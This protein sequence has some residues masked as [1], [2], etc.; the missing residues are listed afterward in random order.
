MTTSNDV[1]RHERS[2]NPRGFSAALE[3]AGHQVQVMPGTGQVVSIFPGSGGAGRTVLAGCMASFLAHQGIKVALLDCGSTFD[4]LRTMFGVESCTSF[5]DISQG[6]VSLSELASS[7]KPNDPCII[8]V[9]PLFPSHAVTESVLPLIASDATQFFDAVIIDTPAVWCGL[10][11][12]L[13]EISSQVLFLMDQRP[14][15]VHACRIALNMCT[16]IGVATH[17]ISFVLNKCKKGCLFNAVD[18]GHVLDGMPVYELKDGGADV[19]EFCSAGQIEELAHS[20]NAFARSI[21]DMTCTL[22]PQHTKE[23]QASI[24]ERAT[25]EKKPRGFALGWGNSTKRGLSQQGFG[26]TR[27]RGRRKGC[28]IEIPRGARVAEPERSPRHAEMAGMP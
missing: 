20:S 24:D 8:G 1:A 9:L 19:D 26:H 12:R 27:R 7:C 13:M 23:A 28:Q 16:R 18:V 22:L 10:H 3:Q 25:S 6:K 4:E 15:S 17:P 11:T 21:A 14:S 5:N 2:G